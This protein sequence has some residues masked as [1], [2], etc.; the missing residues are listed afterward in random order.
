MRAFGLVE[1]ERE[2]G[3][4]RSGAGGIQEGDKEGQQNWTGAIDLC[5][6]PGGTE[7]GWHCK[8]RKGWRCM[9]QSFMLLYR[10]QAA[11]QL[12]CRRAAPNAALAAAAA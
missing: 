7:R 2:D 1:G 6:A 8:E 11:A 12:G 4:V 10:G 5:A 9:G 3:T